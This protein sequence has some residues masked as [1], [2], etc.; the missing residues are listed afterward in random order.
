VLR[1][2][3][4]VMPSASIRNFKAAR[5]NP[6][7]L[8]SMESFGLPVSSMMWWECVILTVNVVVPGLNRPTWR[9]DVA[10]FQIARSLKS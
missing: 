3:G 8:I 5:G 7:L 4:T 9:N 10:F 1:L 6:R 2:E